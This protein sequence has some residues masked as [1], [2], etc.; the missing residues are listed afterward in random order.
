MSRGQKPRWPVFYPKMKNRARERRR[1][2]GTGRFITW[3]TNWEPVGWG[4]VPRAVVLVSTGAES[5]S[6]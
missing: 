2:A 5:D 4:T 3:T 1:K 6:E